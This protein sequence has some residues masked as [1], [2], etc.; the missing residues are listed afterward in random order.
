MSLTFPPN[1]DPEAAM[2]TIERSAC[3][4]APSFVFGYFDLDDIKQ[5]ARMFGLE[6]L[7]R[8][9]GKRPLANFLYVHIRNRL[10]NMKRD[11]LR[12][13]DAPCRGC[14]EGRPCKDAVGTACPA[15]AAWAARNNA[16]A[17][18]MRPFAMPEQESGAGV[19]GS[20]LLDTLCIEEMRERIDR[21]LPVELRS[22]Y[23]KMLDGVPVSRVERAAVAE[24]VRA[25][26]G[27]E[28]DHDEAE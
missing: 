8:W 15:Y 22:T 23:L 25:I 27:G 4:L 12:R 21:E 10:I 6:A 11:L 14:H 13:T 19:S 5:T 28:S 17:S 2:E 9:D 16:K 20:G 3:V 18:L 24:A 1:V 26:L 7:K